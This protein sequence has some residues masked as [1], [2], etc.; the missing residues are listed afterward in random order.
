MYWLYGVSEWVCKFKQWYRWGFL[1]IC[2]DLKLLSWPASRMF[3]RCFLRFTYYRSIKFSFNT[4]CVC[5][6]V[7]VCC[8]RHCCYCSLEIR[9]C[10]TRCTSA[11]NWNWESIREQDE[12]YNQTF[13]VRFHCKLFTDSV[14]MLN[15][16]SSSICRLS[17]AQSTVTTTTKL[18]LWLCWVLARI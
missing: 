7:R 3:S 18:Y 1:Y 5:V 2:H 9:S 4:S 13:P 16:V 11:E 15:C 6:C 17:V 8:L 10:K 14:L 12:K